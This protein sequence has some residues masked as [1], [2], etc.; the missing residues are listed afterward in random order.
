M[1]K[2]YLILNLVYL[3]KFFYYNPSLFKFIVYN[4]YK[5]FNL[6]F[7]KVIYDYMVFY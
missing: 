4:N 5:N 3:Y 6:A 7:F 1:I 2:L